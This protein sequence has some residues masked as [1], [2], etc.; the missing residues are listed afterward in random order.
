M[1]DQNGFWINLLNVINDLQVVVSQLD[2]VYVERESLRINIIVTSGC[3]VAPSVK[4]VRIDAL[5]EISAA[6]KF[7]GSDVISATISDTTT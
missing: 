1:T 5:A 7:S 6:V 2:D 3:F 4:L